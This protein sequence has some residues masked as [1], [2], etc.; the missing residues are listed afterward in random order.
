MWNVSS[1][2][3]LPKV[4]LGLSA[5]IT[6]RDADRDPLPAHLH[7]EVFQMSEVPTLGTHARTH[8]SPHNVRCVAH[9][10]GVVNEEAGRRAMSLCSRFGSCQL[11]EN[12]RAM[13]IRMMR[14]AE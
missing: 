4:M 13:E 14:I 3:F 6:S 9:W 1:T 10:G 8:T 5:F 11:H 2:E 7:M 12:W